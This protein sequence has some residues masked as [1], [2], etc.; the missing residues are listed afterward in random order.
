M[1]HDHDASLS[2]KVLD[3]AKDERLCVGIEA[4]RRLVEKEHGP[5]GCERACER[6]ELPLAARERA[7]IGTGRE[8][9]GADRAHAPLRFFFCAEDAPDI[10]VTNRILIGNRFWPSGALSRSVKPKACVSMGAE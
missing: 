2:A 9:L 5:V 1:R 3:R 7:R 6:H 10:G 4:A 8:M